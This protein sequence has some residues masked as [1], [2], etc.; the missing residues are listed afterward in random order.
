MRLTAPREIL[1]FESKDMYGNSIRLSEYKGR[2]VVLSFFRDTSCPFCLKRV[3]ELRARR[4]QWKKMGVDI[5]TIFSSTEQ[6]IK[7]FSS[8]Q[9]KRLTV[10]ANPDLDIYNLYGVEQSVAGFFKALVFKVPTIISGLAKGAKPT[11][12]P[13]G[14]IMPADFLI[15]DEGTIVDLWYGSNA[16]DH[17]PLKKIENFVRAAAKKARIIELTKEP[18]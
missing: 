12:N 10:I 15:D 17:M 16:A 2:A 1:D 9:P 11:N 14:K 8:D 6:Q 5:I 7:K 3:F 4:K 18:A 13:N